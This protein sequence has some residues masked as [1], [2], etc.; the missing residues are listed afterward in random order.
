MRKFNWGWGITIG[1]TL[2]V[3]YI[4][5]MVFKA[6]T[7]SSDLYAEDYYQQEVN[8]QETIQAKSA[9]NA[10][11]DRIHIYSKDDTI[12]IFFPQEFSQYKTAKVAFYRPNNAA[13]DKTFKVDFDKDGFTQTYTGSDFISGNYTIKIYW[14]IEKKLHLIVKNI[15]Y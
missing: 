1:I 9:G 6:H 11:V 8:F 12:Q 14:E 2:F 4:L 15:V 13:F 5:V 7:I 3:G 10:F